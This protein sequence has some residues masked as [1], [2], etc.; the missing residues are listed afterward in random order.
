MQISGSPPQD[1]IIRGVCTGVDS[2]NGYTRND[3]M[4]QMNLH[5]QAKYH[6]V[7]GQQRSE[8]AVSDC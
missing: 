6:N 4:H 8:Q 3:A 5:E 2:N 1:I 7:I